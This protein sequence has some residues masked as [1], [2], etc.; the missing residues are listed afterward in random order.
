MRRTS[1]LSFFALLFVASVSWGATCQS[2]FE[3]DGIRF[4]SREVSRWGRTFKVSEIVT[5]TKKI[6]DASVIA[7]EVPLERKLVVGFDNGHVYLWHAGKKADSWGRP[8]FDV[9]MKPKFDENRMNGQVFIVLV[10]N[11]GELPARFGEVMEA[12]DGKSDRTC[13]KLMCQFIHDVYPEQGRPFAVNT[14]HFLYEVIG[15]SSPQ[16]YSVHEVVVT[17]RDSFEAAMRAQWTNQMKTMRNAIYGIF[18]RVYRTPPADPP[19]PVE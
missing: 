6:V 13:I 14:Q 9:S 7:P 8:P 3:G 12:F 16:S 18:N 1:L 15:N 5:S 11:R 10:D 2:I 19:M 17:G 4:Q